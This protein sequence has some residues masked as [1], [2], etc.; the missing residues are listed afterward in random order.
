MHRAGQQRPHRPPCGLAGRLVERVR[1][2]RH[3]EPQDRA[4][5]QPCETPA[6][7]RTG[8]RA[9]L[10][11]L[12][13]D[14]AR[15]LG[16]DRAQDHTRPGMGEHLV[17][18]LVQGRERFGHHHRHPGGTA[19]AQRGPQQLQQAGPGPGVRPGGLREPGEGERGGPVQQHP[20]GPP[21]VLREV[22]A[23]LP[24]PAGGQ[25]SPFRLPVRPL[26]RGQRPRQG[27]L[28]AQHPV[29]RRQARELAAPVTVHDQHIAAA[30]EGLEGQRPQQRTRPGPR[31]TDGQQVR[32]GRTRPGTP[33]HGRHVPHPGPGQEPHR[34]GPPDLRAVGEAEH[35][36]PG[37]GD[38][39]LDGDV[40]GQRFERRHLQP[41]ALLVPAEAVLALPAGLGRQHRLDAQAF[42]RFAVPEPGRVAQQQLADAAVAEGELLEDLGPVAT[43]RVQRWR[44]RVAHGGEVG[45]QCLV[46]GPQPGALGLV[47][48]GRRGVRHRRALPAVPGGGTQQGQ[49]GGGASIR[50]Q[51]HQGA[52][53]RE[54]EQRGA[55]ALA[56]GAP[57]PGRAPRRQA[58]Q[59]AAEHQQR[60]ADVQHAVRPR[61]YGVAHPPPG[62]PRR[63]RPP[64]HDPLPGRRPGG[65]PALPRRPVR[66]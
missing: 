15:L 54:Q 56:R 51:P 21:D 62:R 60:M 44:G 63:F 23:A 16:P 55:A 45:H 28:H 10:R 46:Q 20:Q 53:D 27:G 32:L 34:D 35:G 61:P 33:Q 41:V 37:G 5:A 42:G 57:P 65:P 26:Q 18:Q 2:G 52:A 66:A 31:Q 19:V 3:L 36:L 11:R 4:R 1:R 7:R 29:P 50:Q 64:G 59:S 48:A 22:L 13:E 6:G 9:G 43:V 40:G 12:P 49:Q 58:P 39:R 25:Q 17:R 14:R 24:G 47:G 38:E 30:A 8:G